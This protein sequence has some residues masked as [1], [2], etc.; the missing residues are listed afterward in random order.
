MQLPSPFNPCAST[1][2]HLTR[3]S[4]PRWGH[5]SLV[6]SLYFLFN[7][8]DC[9]ELSAP[10]QVVLYILLSC[11]VLLRRTSNDRGK[12]SLIFFTDRN[13]NKVLGYCFH[14]Y[15]SIVICFEFFVIIGK[16]RLLRKTGSGST[17]TIVSIARWTTRL[18]TSLPE[19]TTRTSK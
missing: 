3:L 17:I 12:V 13:L 11:C 1:G 10:C 19:G 9:T 8:R 2:S 14:Q 5:T 16:H 4:E 18:Q 6:P 15:L 7:Y